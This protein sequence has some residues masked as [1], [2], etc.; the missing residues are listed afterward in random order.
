MQD[1][2]QDSKAVKQG[3]GWLKSLA[4]LPLSLLIV[5]IIVLTYTDTGTVIE[6]PYLLA[7]LNILFIALIPFTV[8]YLAW[9]SYVVSGQ[10]RFFLIGCGMVAFGLGAAMAGIVI[11]VIAGLNASVTIFNSGALLAAILFVT[12]AIATLINAPQHKLAS[13]RALRIGLCYL[14]VFLIMSFYCIASY[15]NLVATFFVQGA[16]PTILRQFVLGIATALFA[17]SS[18]TFLIIYSRSRADFTYWFSIALAMIALGLIVVFFQKVVGSPMGWVGR[19]AQYLGCIYM[20]AGIVAAYRISNI[21]RITLE[22]EFARSFTYIE[23]NY[24]T[25]VEMAPNA[26]ISYDKQSRI[27]SWNPAAAKIFGYTEPEAIGANVIDFIFPGESALLINSELQE[28]A[29]AKGQQAKFSKKLETMARRK[30]GEDFPVEV[31]MAVKIFSGEW[32]GTFIIRDIT[33][34]KRAEDS[35]QKSEN[36]MSGVFRAA[37][38]G[39]G[40]VLNRVFVD[41]NDKFCEMLGYSRS[42]LI[43]QSARMIYPSDDDFNFVGKEKYAQ[44]KEQGFGSVETRFKRKNGTVINIILSSTQADTSDLAKGVIFTAQDITE[45]KLAEQRILSQSAV[46]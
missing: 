16:G 26:I 45:R 12:A 17:I 9:C 41:V 38:I 22:N 25:L 18:V 3:F 31:Y 13:H 24:K 20:L 15:E 1:V 11:N 10:M 29:R 34:R 44:I 2:T 8:A 33:E 14:A 35:L 40:M 37:P 42:E 4:L 28:L 23:A 46:L 43:N 36:K 39:I 7:V 32:I 6:P 27:L 5:L 30:Q 21:K 19:A